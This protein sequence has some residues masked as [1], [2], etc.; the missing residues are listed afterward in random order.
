MKVPRNVSGAEL[1]K[2]L[3]KLGYTI[4]R[5][6]GSHIR[7]TSSTPK[8]DHHITVPNHNPMRIGTFSSILSEVAEAQ[9]ISKDELVNRLFA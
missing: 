6:K 8:G 7:M 3:Q 2:S 9:N 4:S 5:Q 1:T